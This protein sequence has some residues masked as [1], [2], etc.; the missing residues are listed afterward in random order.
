M[1]FRRLRK[2]IMWSGLFII[3]V[4]RLCNVKSDQCGICQIWFAHSS[5]AIYLLHTYNQSIQDALYCR[6]RQNKAVLILS[7][8]L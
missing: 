3:L 7:V 5:Y 2:A 4:R 6:E 1:D 8:A